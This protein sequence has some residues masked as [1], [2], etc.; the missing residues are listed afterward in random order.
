MNPRAVVILASI[1]VVAG[2]WFAVARLG[3]K[4]QGGRPLI[5][6]ASSPAVSAPTPSPAASPGSGPAVARAGGSSGSGGSGTLAAT[7]P[8]DQED[9]TEGD[10]EDEP[11]PGSSGLPIVGAAPSARPIP[12]LPPLPLPSPSIP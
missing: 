5:P 3:S 2:V 12:S 11:Q 8:V 7:G 1:L 6:T 4:D 10:V 9:V